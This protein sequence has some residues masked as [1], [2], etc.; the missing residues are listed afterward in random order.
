M[1][2]ARTTTIIIHIVNNIDDGSSDDHSNT[3]KH[4]DGVYVWVLPLLK[5]RLKIQVKQPNKNV[6][7]N[8]THIKQQP[9][10]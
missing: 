6:Q 2:T 9:L 1:I 8:N 7:T 4:I 5:A 10:A 3:N